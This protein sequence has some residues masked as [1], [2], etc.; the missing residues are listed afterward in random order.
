[1]TELRAQYVVV[2]RQMVNSNR[3]VYHLQS[4]IARVWEMLATSAEAVM[5][6]CDTMV[7]RPS[8]DTDRM[9]ESLSVDVEASKLSI[10]ES[11]DAGNILLGDG[12]SCINAGS[13]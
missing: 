9:L 6:D 8:L 13:L 2:L 7:E 10:V 1:M 3:E 4:D 5:R 11:I 12:S